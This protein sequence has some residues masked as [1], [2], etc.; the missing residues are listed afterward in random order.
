MKRDVAHQTRHVLEFEAKINASFSTIKQR[1]L[2]SSI[3]NFGVAPGVANQ[4]SGV[5][6]PPWTPLWLRHCMKGRDIQVM[7]PRKAAAHISPIET[8]LDHAQEEDI[9]LVEWALTPI[10]HCEPTEA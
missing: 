2:N 6:S 8:L 9:P 7:K 5:S 10:G 4:M 3:L 1:K